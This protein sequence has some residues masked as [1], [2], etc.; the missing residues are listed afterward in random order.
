[1]RYLP[2]M[3]LCLVLPIAAAGAQDDS[4]V[5]PDDIDS[6]FGDPDD[7]A[8]D[9]TAGES[10]G[11]TPE[12]GSWDADPF[13]EDDLDSLFGEEAGTIREAGTILNP[14]DAFLESG[15][16][17]WNGR[18]AGSA[19]AQI[20]WRELPPSGSEWSEYSDALLFALES[21]LSFDARP[22]RDYRVAGTFRI[23][24]PF[25]ASITGMNGSTAQ[26]PSIGIYEL[27]ADFSRNDRLFF[28]FGKQTAAWGLSRFY[29]P[30]DPISTEVKNPEKAGETL[31]GPLALR[32]TL[33]VGLHTL[34][35]Y[36]VAKD[37]YLPANLGELGLDNLGYG[38]KADFFL[39][40]PERFLFSDTELSL[41]AYYQKD[42]AP[43]AV[44]G[45]STSI[46]KVA[47][48]TDQVL[49]WGADSFRLTDEELF[50]GSGIYGTER[51]EDGLFYSATLGFMYQHSDWHMTLYG[52]YY[53]NG[54]GST[55]PGYLEKLLA[56]FGA[57]NAVPPIPGLERTLSVSDLAG[58]QSTHNSAVSLAFSELFGSD[59]WSANL[60][61]QQ[62]W[63]DRS[64]LVVPSL[65]FTPWKY[66][67]VTAGARLAF[68]DDGTE[69]V[70]KLSDMSSGEPRRLTGYIAVSLGSGRF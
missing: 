3:I 62:N 53:Y 11:E 43:R 68:G 48:F 24:Y 2:A 61:W 40:T 38:L 13:G 37:S 27:F 58:Y 42:L 35:G 1:M 59:D 15:G 39:P 65:T 63:I 34:F 33:P 57:E 52:E 18:F 28:R 22:E 44:L 47:L 29:Q 51:P 4:S 19:E 31:E 23:R 8:A 26:V 45:L 41:G 50:P 67:S 36:V 66:L 30:A 20:R 25:F 64:G 6:L 5:F 16:V 17:T 10:G 14:E 54:Y 55:D 69:F 32:I 70:M 12:P 46:G 49:S 7:G 9:G 21:R 56:R 60:F